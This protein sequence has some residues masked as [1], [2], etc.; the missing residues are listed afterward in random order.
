M[1][2]EEYRSTY[3]RLRNTFGPTIARQIVDG[4]DAD[5]IKANKKE[6]KRLAEV[7]RIRQLIREELSK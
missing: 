2:I 5:R 3:D 4:L 7:E 1:S 6:A